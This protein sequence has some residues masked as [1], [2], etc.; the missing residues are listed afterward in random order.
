MK[1]KISLT[2]QKTKFKD[3]LIVPVSVKPNEN[4]NDPI[5]KV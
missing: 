4:E 3:A 5:G 2:L 1:K